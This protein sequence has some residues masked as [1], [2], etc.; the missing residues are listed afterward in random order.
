MNT[1]ADFWTQ[2]VSGLYGLA[3]PTR[4]LLSWARESRRDPGIVGSEVLT[5]E[6]DGLAVGK[7]YELPGGDVRWS[8]GMATPAKGEGAA[9]TDLRGTVRVDEVTN[10]A[11]AVSLDLSA[12]MSRLDRP[13]EFDERVRG[14]FRLPR[15]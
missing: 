13:G 8:Y 15:R 7:T 3:A 6:L 5:L 11:V 10:L 9:A 4:L 14:R 12:T 1:V 2:D